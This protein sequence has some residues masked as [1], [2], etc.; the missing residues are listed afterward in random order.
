MRAQE[1]VQAVYE[2]EKELQKEIAD[3]VGKALCKLSDETGLT[4]GSVTI[5][6]TES[7]HLVSTSREWKVAHIEIDYELPHKIWMG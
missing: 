3:A 6:T 2:T 1:L 7:T 4:L 5:N